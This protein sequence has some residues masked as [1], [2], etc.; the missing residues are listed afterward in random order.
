MK[1]KQ[2]HKHQKTAHSKHRPSSSV[3]EGR[4]EI[5]GRVGFVIT[6]EPGKTDVLVQGASLNLALN[7]DRVAVRVRSTQ[8]DGRRLGEIVRVIEHAREQLVGAYR[9][10]HNVP[11]IEPEAG[12]NSIRITNM[13]GLTPKENDLVVIR[14]VTW[15][16]A[17]KGAEGV[18]ER[19]LGPRSAPGVDL[20]ILIEKFELPYR[21]PA[22]VEK[23]AE[24]FGS[25]V[26][27]SALKGRETLF[28]KIV[29]TID[30]ADAKDFDDAVS[31]ELRPGG[32]WKLGVHIADVS[33]YVREGSELDKEAY[34]RGTSVYLTGQVIPMLPF[35]LSDN[36][37]SLRPDVVRL[38][39]SCEIE[40]DAGG[41]V[42]GQRVFESAIKSAKRFT[43]EEV[44]SILR[45]QGENK[46]PAAI[47]RDVKIMGVLADRL[48]KKRFSRGSLDF[49]FPEPYAVLD[50]HGRIIDI[51]RRERL[52]SHRL[53]EDFMLLANETTARFMRDEPFIY[54]VHEKPDPA[55]LKTLKATLESVGVPV[56]LHFEKG[57]PKALQAVIQACHG[58]PV[59]SMVHMMI[60]RSLKQAVYSEAN[61]GHYGLASVCYTHFTSPIRRYPDLIVHRLIREKLRD[62]L[63]R[64]LKKKWTL[65]MPGIAEHSSKRE[66]VAV[67]AEREFLDVQRVRLMENQVGKTFSGVISSVT[68]FGLFVVLD[69]PFV[70]G[71]V[72]VANL[73]DDYY[74][75]D[76]VR[77]TLRG[78]RSG[79][80]FRVG[81]TV[82]VL[83]AGADVVK[84]QLD[85]E[86][87]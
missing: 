86:L 68:R 4:L 17:S 71:L 24:S 45:G 13:N 56:P 66:R 74:F 33:H 3:V 78:K 41:N 43:Y 59:Q 27:P 40:V 30:G 83:L 76:E 31:V 38:T 1:Q 11:H 29:V 32:G 58:K 7:G 47:V 46:F 85:F 52:E 44:E 75:F 55:K 14:I 22:A 57:N 49:D 16:T 9:R 34:E 82:K 67:D 12:G 73:K 51:R 65:A 60:L 77:V 64:D 54:R 50:P 23:E 20:Q 79:R 39:L 61:K 15:P 19:V 36:L 2:F 62:R 80:M 81:Q 26:P 48:R 42:V 6:A 25:E 18:L 87:T 37:C 63:N 8:A 5:K 72:H 53:V 70:E 84:H 21:F 35:P 69:E 28:D 10:F